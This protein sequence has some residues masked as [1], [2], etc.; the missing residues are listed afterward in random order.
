[1]IGKER[2]REVMSHFASGVTVVT[3]RDRE[4]RPV[5]L[6]VSAFT[7]VSLEPTL[8]LICVHAGA[9]SHDAIIQRGTFA[10]NI[11]SAHQG[12]L[13]TRFA[14]GTPQERFQGLE[15]TDGPLGN[16]LIPDALAWLECR[17][18][19]VWPGGDHSVILGEVHAC[20]GRPGAP[21]LFFRGDLEGMAT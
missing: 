10:V 19:E 21:L 4:E 13:A 14:E 16:P 3:T 17:L 20:E 7:S 12:P 9:D 8:L 15:V 11:L 6:T 5:G 1:M 18:R 2:F